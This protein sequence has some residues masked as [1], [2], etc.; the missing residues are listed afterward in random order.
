[1]GMHRS[2]GGSTVNYQ[3]LERL[4][5]TAALKVKL[6]GTRRGSVAFRK[7]LTH[8]HQVLR[9]YA[10]RSLRQAQGRLFGGSTVNYQILERLRMTAALKM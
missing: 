5:M 8:L 3:I 9:V 2:F 7:D 1:M 4:R 6:L 10:Y